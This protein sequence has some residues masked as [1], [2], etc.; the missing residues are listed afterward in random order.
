MVVVSIATETDH[1]KIEEKW[2]KKW[3]DAK[4]FQSDPDSREKYFCNAAFPY[5]NAPL[6]LGH[7][8][9]YTRIDV[10]ARFKRMSGFNT[11]YPFA[12]HATG[13][14]I[15]GVA[16]RLEK[17]DEKQRNI[18]LSSGIP[19]K[20][21][22]KFRDPKYIVM[23]WKKRIEEDMNDL[24]LSVDWRRKFTTIDPE[25]NK[26]ISWQYRFLKKKG[27]VVQGTHPVV[28]CDHCKSPTG[29]HDRLQGEGESPIDFTILKFKFK[30]KYICAATLRPETVFGQTNMWADPEVEYSVVL[31]NDKEKW[32]VSE[33]CAEKLKEQGK[34]IKEMGK[35]QGKEMI[36]KYCTA[37]MIDN[38]IMILPS[39]FCDP[40][41]GT[42]LVTSVP[43]HAPYDWQALVDLKNN[44]EELRKYGIDPEEVRKIEPISIIRLDG[45]GE[46]PAQEICEQLGIKSQKETEK[47]D[48]ALKIIYKK[49]HHTGVMKDNCGEY[50][51]FRVEVAK[52][53][54]KRELTRKGL[55][56]AIW[57]PT[58]KVVC[59]CGTQCYIKILENQ[60]FLKFSD[61]RW[62]QK[63][64]E[65]LR[66]MKIYPDSGR[67]NFE[68]T[69]EWLRDKACARR[70]GLGTKLPWDQEWIIETLSDSVIY[71]AYYT[72]AKYINEKGMQPDQLTDELFN[73]ILRGEGDLEKVSEQTKIDKKTIKDMKKEFDYWYG[74]DLRGSAK[75]LIPNHLTYCLFHHTAMWDD[76]TRWP[77]AMTVNGMLN[78][79]GQKMSKSKG[80]FIVLRDAIDKYG[81]DA[82]RITL[83]DCGEGMNDINWTENDVLSWKSKL[84]SIY[85]LITDN[86]NQGESRLENTMD[87]WLVSRLENHIKIMT[88]ALDQTN[89]RTAATEIHQMVNDMS[90]YLKR[91]EKPNQGVVDYFLENFVK[92]LSP[93]AP[94]IAEEI[95]EK[96]KKKGFLSLE[97]W[98]VFD[99]K[100]IDDEIL[101]LEESF[102]KMTEDI[103]E[104]IKLSGKNDK[105]HLYV[106]SDKELSH[107]DEGKSFLKKEL[108]FKE[109]NIYILSDPKKYDP[110]GKAKRAKF[111]KPGIYVE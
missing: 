94:F 76:Q 25:F 103:K 15:V 36:G 85:H 43:S 69:I 45:F 75:E 78:I 105:L 89:N 49:E 21:I 5:V 106:V 111:G 83:M 73:Y 96:L 68:S 91:T 52:E 72:I 110:E 6:H 88:Q 93:F 86:Y 101:Q 18:L 82:V 51:G 42:G 59:R 62:K 67:K 53:D 61:E 31:V 98:P 11:I 32:I 66:M 16:T 95:W 48:K 74:F 108:A 4:I 56:D 47:L 8:F 97:K 27:Y 58:E 33:Q 70:S 63:T 41:I 19:E 99:Q 50:S 13:E 64:R 87:K 107:F 92:L 1:R 23:F 84:N 20:D 57:E 7:G 79:E 22:S 37:P 17:G 38:E 9:T 34:T 44:P 28:W 80:N 104:V 39:K 81:S 24:G 2:K 102:K 10:M 54:V 109:A 40:N 12:F 90:W 14:P 60:W 71:P 29:D 100:K 30:D 35:I 77:N 65:C 55:A 26:F 46:H 3:L